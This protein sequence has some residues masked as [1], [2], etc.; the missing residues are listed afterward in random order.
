MSSG[1]FW[2]VLVGSGGFCEV[3]ASSD[4]FLWGAGW[5]GES[6]IPADILGGGW[7][8]L[9][10]FFGTSEIRR[11]PPEKKQYNP[12]LRVARCGKMW[13]GCQQGSGKFWWVLVGSG[14][15]L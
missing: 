10:Y 15:F 6:K 14:G 8:G 7:R 13:Q 9:E 2:W 5:C 11:P 4:G 3:L 12:S 1:G